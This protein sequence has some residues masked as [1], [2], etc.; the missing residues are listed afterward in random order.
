M[1]NELTF[2]A[3]GNLTADP[4]LRFTQ[5]GIPVASFTV[6]HTPRYFDRDSQQWQDRDPI[7]IRC[8]VWRDAAEHVAESLEKGS[9]VIAQGVFRDS[10]YTDK[11][12]NARTSWDLVVDELGPSL[13]YAT[14][15]VTKATR[16]D[17]PPHPADQYGTTRP[18]GYGQGGQ[19][20][21]PPQ[22]GAG[23]Y[24]PQGGAQPSELGY[25]DP[26]F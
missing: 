23:G 3:I 13:R 21:E 1:P 4:E 8:S 20:Y 16:G 10:S 22:G 24:S 17:R 11:D 12:G 9:R 26:P 15:K 6:A 19:G 7:F 25:E 2:T 5:S 18:T 14:A